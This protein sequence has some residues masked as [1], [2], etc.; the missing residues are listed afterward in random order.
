MSRNTD[1]PGSWQ[2]P[3]ATLIHLYPVWVQEG[4]S[5]MCNVITANYILKASCL[6]SLP[7]RPQP[8]SPWDWGRKQFSPPQL[9]LYHLVPLW[10][11]EPDRMWQ[12]ACCHHSSLSLPPSC[13]RGIYYPDHFRLGHPGGH[14]SLNF[15]TVTSQ[16]C[17]LPGGREFPLVLA[18]TGVG[19]KRDLRKAGELAPRHPGLLWG[20]GSRRQALCRGEPPAAL[21][22]VE[23]TSV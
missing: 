7:A 9:C 3:G 18:V 2:S 11:P 6:Y 22:P 19:Q 4:L 14:S 1:G 23:V 16:L 13:Q 5:Q 17:P 8:L 21:W 15:L 12:A 10:A 20:G